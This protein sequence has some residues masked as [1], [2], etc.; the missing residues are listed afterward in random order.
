MFYQ[1]PRPLRVWTAA[2]VYAVLQEI[3]DWFDIFLASGLHVLHS[4]ARSTSEV[5]ILQCGSVAPR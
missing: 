5:K 3:L 4:K 2:P 1:F